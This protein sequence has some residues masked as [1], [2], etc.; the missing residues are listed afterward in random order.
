MKIYKS[1]IT[2]KLFTEDA[3]KVLTDIFGEEEWEILLGEGTIMR[4]PDY[5]YQN[6]TPIAKVVNK[7]FTEDGVVVTLEKC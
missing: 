1:S 3:R 2:G 7:K 6:K 4:L 5:E